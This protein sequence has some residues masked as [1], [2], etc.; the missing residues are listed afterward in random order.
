[1]ILLW[2]FIIFLGIGF[3]WVVYEIFTAPLMP[4]DYD[5]D[6]TPEELDEMFENYSAKKSSIDD[7]DFEDL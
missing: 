5:M 3:I 7:E 1:M 4:D 2:L 6:F